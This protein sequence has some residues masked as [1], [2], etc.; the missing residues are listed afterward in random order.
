M[1]SSITRNQYYRIFGLLHNDGE[2]YE[3]RRER[4]VIANKYLAE[5]G[6]ADFWELTKTE[7]ENLIV[8]LEAVC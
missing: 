1:M 2:D 5:L 8:W 3:D 4:K 6:K 7:A